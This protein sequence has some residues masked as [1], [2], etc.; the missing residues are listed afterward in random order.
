[1]RSSMTPDSVASTSMPSTSTRRSL[2]HSAAGPYCGRQ[3]ADR[4]RDCRAHP[5]IRAARASATR[6]RDEHAGRVS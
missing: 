5:T 4:S 6:G 3:A 1:L 2:S